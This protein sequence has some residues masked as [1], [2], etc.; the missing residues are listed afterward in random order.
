MKAAVV[1]ESMFGNTARV[2]QAIAEGMREAGAAAT[3]VPVAQASPEDATDCEIVVIGAP[4]HAFT[5]S[6]S[7]SRATAVRDGAPDEVAVQGVRE[8]LTHATPRASVLAVFDTRAR[9]MRHWPGSA[10]RKAARV[11]RQRGEAP[12]TRPCSFYVQSTHGPLLEGEI[13][14]ARAWGT[15]L[16]S[17]VR[18]PRP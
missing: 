5:L 9:S 8:W 14:R 6:T 12:T 2:A 15:A 7:K 18:Q 13:D 4:T 16:A 1:Y 11:L 3:L 17:Q 10:A